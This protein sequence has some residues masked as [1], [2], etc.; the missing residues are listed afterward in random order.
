MSANTLWEEVRR[1]AALGLLAAFIILIDT[2]ALVR[3]GVEAW[4]GVLFLGVVGASSY[5]WRVRTTGDGSAR[6]AGVATGIALGVAIGA[7]AREAN[8][9]PLV[10]LGVLGILALEP[11]L[12][13]GAVITHVLLFAAAA[14]IGF[15]ALPWSADA[16]ILQ[17]SAG[18]GVGAAGALLVARGAPLR[19]ASASMGLAAGALL[20]GWALV[21][22]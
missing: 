3:I 11:P 8:A 2:R 7:L 15:V 12:G 22:W 10:L 21:R 1:S 14:T 16:R 18:F 5:A 19:W 9:V 20:L 13:I 4:T 17:A 6:A